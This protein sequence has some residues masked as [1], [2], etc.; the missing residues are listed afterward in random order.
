MLHH[1]S[2]K[3]AIA[4]SVLLLGIACDGEYMAEDDYSN[5]S[6]TEETVESEV[7]S[8]EVT[9]KTYTY[10]AKEVEGETKET[11]SLTFTDKVE[12]FTVNLCK[13]EGDT[14]TC[15]KGADGSPDGKT[16]T[17]SKFPEDDNLYVIYAYNKDGSWAYGYADEDK[18]DAAKNDGKDQEE[19]DN[20]D[21]EAKE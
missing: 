2:Y 17:F 16:W 11:V 20:N 9:L 21:N 6:N 19:D 13:I 15:W 7:N 12:E 5:T 18:I 1:I 14:H 4:C 8:G 3:V 10:E